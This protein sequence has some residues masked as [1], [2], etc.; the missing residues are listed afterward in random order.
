MDI[1]SLFNTDHLLFL[2]SPKGAL[3]VV[4]IG[5][6][7]DLDLKNKICKWNQGGM[8]MESQFVQLMTTC[9]CCPTTQ[10]KLQMSTKILLYLMKHEDPY[11]ESNVI[12]VAKK[13]LA[14]TTGGDYWVH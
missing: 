6:T 8:P 4:S 2:T 14:V 7:I 10:E 3:F 13:L 9:S 11:F 5:D 1:K 12:A